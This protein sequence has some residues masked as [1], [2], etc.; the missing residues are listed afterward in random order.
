LL[1]VSGTGRLTDHHLLINPVQRRILRH[2]QPAK[3]SLKLLWPC[4]EATFRRTDSTS[5]KT[6]RINTHSSKSLCAVFHDISAYMYHVIIFVAAHL[7]EYFEGASSLR[8]CILRQVNGPCQHKAQLHSCPAR[9]IDEARTKR[10]V[11]KS[12]RV[13]HKTLYSTGP[14]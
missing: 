4:R 11:M 2:P 5:K 3:H 14:R 12:G 8:R 6:E 1:V 13:I 10:R 9:G 7:L